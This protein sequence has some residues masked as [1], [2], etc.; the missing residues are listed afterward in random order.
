L[1]KAFLL[2]EKRRKSKQKNGIRLRGRRMVPE[3]GGGG[4]SPGRVDPIFWKKRGRKNLMD[5]RKILHSMKGKASEGRGIEETLVSG[6]KGEERR[7]AAGSMFEADMKG[8]D[9]RSRRER[10]ILREIGEGSIKDPL[11]KE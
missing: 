2:S 3:G 5:W 9:R 10:G 8:K 7:K 4:K 1:H 11:R 6:K